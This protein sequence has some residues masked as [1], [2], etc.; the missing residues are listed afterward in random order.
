MIDGK[1]CFKCLFSP[2]VGVLNKC[3]GLPDLNDL[4]NPYPKKNREKLV[5]VFQVFFTSTA[6]KWYDKVPDNPEKYYQDQQDPLF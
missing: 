1:T 6:Y 2:N 5:L 4:T 3:T